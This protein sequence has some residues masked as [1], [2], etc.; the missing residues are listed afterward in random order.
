MTSRRPLI[1][2]LLCATALCSQRSGAQLVPGHYAFD[3]EL[4]PVCLDGAYQFQIGSIDN[5][6]LSVTTDDRG[7]VS[8]TVDFRTIKTNV[9]G[10]IRAT[11]KSVVLTLK[12]TDRKIPFR[13]RAVLEGSRFV[14]VARSG[15]KAPCA[16]EVSATS[17][18]NATYEF[19]VTVDTE[20]RVGGGGTVKS[21][22]R[23]I[24]ITVRGSTNRKRST[25]RLSSPE[26]TWSGTGKTVQNG[27]NAAW[28]A[29]LFGAN[30]HGE[31]LLITAQ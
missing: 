24:A 27:F 7:R 5:A 8:G 30:R 19:D 12:G 28:I 11:E 29:R 10:K 3:L 25:L 26:T 21:G 31:G 2:A 22:R 14:G 23:Q 18:L 16:M 6:I 13:A 17:P 4:A 20:G 9:V 1:A 15:G